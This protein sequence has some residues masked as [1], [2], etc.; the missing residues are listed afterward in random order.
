VTRGRLPQRAGLPG[1]NGSGAAA[2][3]APKASQVTHWAYYKAHVICNVPVKMT[4]Y[5]DII[6]QDQFKALRCHHYEEYRQ[7]DLE[8]KNLHFNQA[9]AV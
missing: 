2:A 8:I 5:Q 3:V 7:S 6:Q 9:K 4:L 1:L